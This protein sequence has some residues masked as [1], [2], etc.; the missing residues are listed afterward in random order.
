[1]KNKPRTHSFIRDYDCTTVYGQ[2]HTQI[3]QYKAGKPKPGQNIPRN[4]ALVQG[5][6]TSQ[7]QAFIYWS[8]MTFTGPQKQVIHQ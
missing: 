2:K 1:M 7:S 5:Q 6:G 8:P 4:C 3:V